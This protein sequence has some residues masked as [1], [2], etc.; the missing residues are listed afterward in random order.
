MNEVFDGIWGLLGIILIVAIIIAIYVVLCKI[1]DNLTRHP[2][3]RSYFWYI[4]LF[5]P[6]F[7]VALGIV[8]DYRDKAVDENVR[9]AKTYKAASKVKADNVSENKKKLSNSSKK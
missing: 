1:L 2:N 5:G 3:G 6:F 8:L 7:G 4:F 9:A